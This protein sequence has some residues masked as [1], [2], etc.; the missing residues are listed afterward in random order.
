MTS[1]PLAD[2]IPAAQPYTP[3]SDALRSATSDL[4]SR[5]ERLEQRVE[6]APPATPA[7]PQRAKDGKDIWDVIQILGSALIPVAIAA[8]GWFYSE[9]TSRAQIE[10]S[11]Q[12]HERNAEIATAEARV[13]QAGLLK[14]FMEALT[15]GDVAKRRV[16]IQA[17]LIA[18]PKDGPNLVR[19]F[20]QSTADSTA[21]AFARTALSQR[22]QALVERLFGPIA[23][24]R[25]AASA[26]LI[27]GWGESPVLLDKLLPYAQQHLD[28]ANGVFN[29]LGVLAQ[30]KPAV[31]ESRH[32]AVDVFLDGAGR[33]PGAGDKIRGLI[34]TVRVRMRSARQS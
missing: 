4:A 22:C 28:N 14:D 33:A 9:A 32:P 10:S 26:A 25:I 23:E 29:S 30:V 5:L 17:V 27:D 20:T 16:A 8:G 13:K 15:G 18:L 1:K 2:E 19:E 11:R 34:T 31:L 24:D 3:A 6:A 21:A 12:Q 7:P